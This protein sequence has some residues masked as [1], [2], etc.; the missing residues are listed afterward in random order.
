V[1]QLEIFVVV[2]SALF[3]RDYM[4]Y[5]GIAFME[6]HISA[7]LAHHCISRHDPDA[8][9]F[10]RFRAILPCPLVGF[11]ALATVSC[12]ATRLACRP[13]CLRCGWHYS[14]L[15][16]TF[17]GNTLLCAVVAVSRNT[18]RPL[19]WSL[20]IVSVNF[21]HSPDEHA[22]PLIYSVDAGAV[23]L[24]IVGLVAPLGFSEQDTVQDDTVSVAFKTPVSVP[25]AVL[26][27]QSV[28]R[29]FVSPCAIT[30]ISG[31]VVDIAAL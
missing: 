7:G 27:P 17:L 24:P 13:A 21:V 8:C 9:I 4:V 22:R 18:Y 14:T 25:A 15:T 2:R 5:V 12:P 1:K 23:T 30:R 16:L 3:H 29:T 26:S 31:A 11:L 6:H 20:A 10:P 19:V 28:S